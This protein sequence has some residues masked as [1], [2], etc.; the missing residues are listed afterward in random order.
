M[1]LRTS[2]DLD[3]IFQYVSIRLVVVDMAVPGSWWGARSSDDIV[4]FLGGTRQGHCSRSMT[5]GLDMRV[6]N[7]V[8]TQSLISCGCESIAEVRCSSFMNG[9]GRSMESILGQHIE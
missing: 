2:E 6:L 8:D 5:R 3:Q 4:T 7:D 9:G 1:Y